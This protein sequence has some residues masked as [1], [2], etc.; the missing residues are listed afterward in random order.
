M[1]EPKVGERR[2]FGDQLAEWDGKGWAAVE[3]N[4]RQSMGAVNGSERNRVDTNMIGFDHAKM[5]D[6]ASKLP[7]PLRYPAAFLGSLGGTA[8]EAFSAPE[9]VA[10]MGIGRVPARIPM[11]VSHPPTPIRDAIR[12]AG[13][14]L[15]T[16]MANPVTRMAG[17][18]MER[19][20]VP[21]TFQDLPL[22]QQMEHLPA[23][24]APERMMRG[25]PPQV[26]EV[27][28]HQRPLYQQMQ[29]LPATSQAP[30]GAGRSSMPPVAG[31]A[32]TSRLK[33]MASQMMEKATNPQGGKSLSD[34]EAKF[35]DSVSEQL[36]AGR[37]LTPKQSALFYSIYSRLMH[38]GQ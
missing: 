6:L 29:E 12:M 22:A 2:I 13:A 38:K 27:P 36:N 10:M 16:P 23:T 3:P 37:D 1:D 8:L 5:A 26:P 24:P 17:R 7:E 35:V 34:F 9:S 21:K 19:V 14:G 25:G 18:V 15:D 20:P 33:D 11:A 31:G 32:S 30:S 4:P 28:F